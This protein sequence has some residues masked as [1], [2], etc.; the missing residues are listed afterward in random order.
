MGTL[1][2][3]FVVGAVTLVLTYAAI[4][5]FKYLKWLRLVI[6]SVS[7]LPGPKPHWFF[8]NI[9][10]VIIISCWIYIAFYHVYVNLPLFRDN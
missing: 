9:F 2:W 8:G 5:I 1:T 10:Q 3:T 6:T 4:R 7:K